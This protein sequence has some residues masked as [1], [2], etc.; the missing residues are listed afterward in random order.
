[1][2]RV[3]AQPIEQTDAL[4]RTTK[5]VYDDAGRVVRVEYPDPDG[6]GPQRSP[7]MLTAY[8]LYGRAVSEIRVLGYEDDDPSRPMDDPDDL[9]STFV[10]DNLHRLIEETDG[11][12]DTISSSLKPQASPRYITAK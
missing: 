4:G 7:I 9:T 12:G 11:N 3:A 5:Y 2:I 8:D 1:M 6:A 10:Y